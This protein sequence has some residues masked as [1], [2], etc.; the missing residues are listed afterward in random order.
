[1]PGNWWVENVIDNMGIV[2]LVSWTVAVIGSIVLHELAHGWATISRGDRTPI[3][4]G[5]MT[6]NPLV[7]MGPMSLALFAF[8]GIAFG[9]MPVDPSRQ[10]GRY[11]SAYVAFA[12]PAM[13]LLI[14]AVFIVIGALVLNGR[15]MLGDPLGPNLQTFCFLIVFLNISLALFNLIPVP[16]LDGWRILSDFVP[17]YGRLF[18]SENG[19][20]IGIGL[21]V[22]VFIFAGDFIFGPGQFVASSW[23]PQVAGLLGGP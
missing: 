5:H 6:W 1:M 13:N 9:A 23:I 7:H 21:F 17:E 10:R 12:G 2:G 14:A 19:R 16:P 4:L 3:E 15:S 22:L 11:A 20:W 8:F 18:E